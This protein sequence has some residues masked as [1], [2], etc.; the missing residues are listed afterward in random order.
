MAKWHAGV[1]WS[2][3][4][5]EPG[6][7]PYMERNKKWQVNATRLFVSAAN[8]LTKMDL[9]PLMFKD[10]TVGMSSYTLDFEQS[11]SYQSPVDIATWGDI[12]DELP[13]VSY[14]MFTFLHFARKVT[15]RYKTISE[16]WAEIGGLW[17]AATLV[18]A[19]VFSQSGTTDPKNKKPS[20]IFNFLPS[21]MRKRW[22]QENNVKLESA[23]AAAKDQTTEDPYPDGKDKV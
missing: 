17:A 7:P 22:I 20:V 3:Y 13:V 14:M 1:A 12:D 11:T 6:I 8:T 2:V 15:I 16:I 23:G 9:R 10:E 18:M 4:F 21:K 5:T 19:M